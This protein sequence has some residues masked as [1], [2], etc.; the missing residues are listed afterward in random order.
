MT[1]KQHHPTELTSSAL[2]AT[3]QWRTPDGTDKSAWA[4]SALLDANIHFALPIRTGNRY[5]RQRNYHGKY[6]FSQT[7]RHVW[8]ESLLEASVL[9]WLD[10]HCTIQA[11]TSQPMTIMFADG[12]S[13]TPDFLALHDDHRQVVYDVKPVKFL[14]DKVL[15]QF[16][17]TRELCESIGWGYEVHTG[18]TDQV[19]V[20]LDW[21]A[22]FK[23]PGYHPGPVATARLLAAMTGPMTVREAARTLGLGTLAEGRSAVYHLTW[24]QVLTVD[25]TH[26]ISDTTP[27]ERNAHAHA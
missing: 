25:L 16:A 20:N 10:M 22:A 15:S 23:H 17:K 7:R 4:T 26:R 5:P 14:T 6:Y 1:D 27:L 11:I 19:R 18:F 9:T 8:H 2:P 13:H 3:V 24:T 21:F 12:L